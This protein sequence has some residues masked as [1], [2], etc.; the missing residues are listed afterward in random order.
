MTENVVRKVK[1]LR[2]QVNEWFLWG[3]SKKLI[4]DNEKIVD[5]EKDCLTESDFII[6][7]GTLA[8][9]VDDFDEVALRSSLK[10]KHKIKGTINLLEIFLEENNLAE[11]NITRNLR[12]IKRI[13]NT[14]FPYHR[15][16]KTEFLELI[17]TLGLKLPFNWKTIWSEC[18]NLYINAIAELSDRLREYSSR[19]EYQKVEEE[20]IEKLEL[21]E[22]VIYLND[23]LY[24]YRVLIPIKLG[25]EA[26]TLVDYLTAAIIAYDRNLKS[27]N[28]ALRKYVTRLEDKYRKHA[29]DPSFVKKRRFVNNQL[30]KPY[31]ILV[32]RDDIGIEDDKEFQRYFRYI[33]IAFV[34]YYAGVTPDWLIREYYPSYLNES[35]S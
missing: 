26:K 35:S 2:E 31:G 27:I 16:V 3:H 29:E 18:L 32:S 25:N 5:L 6:Q 28:Y 15:G 13:R 21:Q 10:R 34:A 12:L 9:I 1:Q 22:D 11:G 4:K 19:I 7:I 24:K 14:T 30:L 8:T 20:R 23:Y 17:K 33:W